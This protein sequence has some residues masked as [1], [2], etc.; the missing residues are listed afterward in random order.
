MRRL[1]RHVF[2]FLSV[3]LYSVQQ[4][5]EQYFANKPNAPRRMK[6]ETKK[7]IQQRMCLSCVQVARCR[8]YVLLFER[9]L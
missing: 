6:N 1:L 3:Y 8:L 2:F 4:S 7:S 5:A 9:R